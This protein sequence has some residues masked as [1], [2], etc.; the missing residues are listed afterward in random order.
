MRIIVGKINLIKL[1]KKFFLNNLRNIY[2]FVKVVRPIFFPS[3]IDE[4]Q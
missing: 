4:E 2:F 1:L 3:I